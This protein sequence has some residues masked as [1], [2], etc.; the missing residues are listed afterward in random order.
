MQVEA[1]AIKQANIVLAVSA[2]LNVSRVVS[3]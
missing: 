1:Q 2:Q 3:T